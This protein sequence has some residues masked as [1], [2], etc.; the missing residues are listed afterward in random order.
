MIKHVLDFYWL[1]VILFRKFP[2]QIPCPS[3]IYIFNVFMRHKQHFSYNL[4]TTN[5]CRRLG[6]QNESPQQQH[7]VRYGNTCKKISTK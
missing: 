7:L 4:C 1:G 2:L 5:P 3:T 6:H